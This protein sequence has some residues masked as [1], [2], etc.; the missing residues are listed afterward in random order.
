MPYA[1][2]DPRYEELLLP[3][4]KPIGSVVINWSD[5]ITRGMI[6]CLPLQYS[7]IDLVSGKKWSVQDQDWNAFANGITHH[8]STSNGKIISPDGFDFNAFG[9]FTVLIV[10]KNG[11]S[12]GVVWRSV[13]AL[14]GTTYANVAY[15]QYR[16]DTDSMEFFA[17]SDVDA[18][19]VSGVQTN[20]PQAYI[21]SANQSTGSKLIY[22]NGKNLLDVTGS[23]TFA[24]G[25]K[26][27][28]YLWVDNLAGRDN[29]HDIALGVIWNRQ[30]TKAESIAITKDPF[31]FVIPA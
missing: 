14:D 31:R 3:R 18:I 5:P 2:P 7:F 4:A 23:F 9:E 12:G 27:P 10:W 25:I 30:L 26:I 29:D 22:K 1:I 15:L 13:F 20:A 21:F 28:K 19:T 8:A 24:S 6:S 11:G 16:E 17:G